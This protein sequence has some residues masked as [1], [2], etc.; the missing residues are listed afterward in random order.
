MKPSKAE[1]RTLDLITVH[2]HWF[3]ANRIRDEYFTNVKAE[4]PNDGD[5]VAFFVTGQGMYLCLWF[6]L[7]FAVFEALRAR[8]FVVPDAQKEIDNLFKRL[9]EFRN[10]TFHVQR[11]YLSP[12]FFNLLNDPT[13]QSTL[14]KAHKAV[15]SW[16]ANE[17]GINVQENT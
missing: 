12:K 2:R 3:W 4:P 5:L 8:Q 16:L 9:K 17:L 11:D 15:G 7:A 10:A 1:R 14:D 6:G 13:H